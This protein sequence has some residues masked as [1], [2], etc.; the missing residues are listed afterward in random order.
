MDDIRSI[1]SSIEIV[2]SI[3]KNNPDKALSTEIDQ[4]KKAL[5][6]L[7]NKMLGETKQ[8]IYRKPDVINNM[9]GRT[10]YLLDHILEPA[11]NNQLNSINQLEQTISTFTS[12][13]VSYTHL[14]LPTIH[15]V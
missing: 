14:T 10:G 3:L 11:N 12:D 4:L 1:N 7:T 9:I 8:G 2:E 13:P 6:K 15:L 5:K